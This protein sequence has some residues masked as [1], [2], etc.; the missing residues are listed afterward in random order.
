L[1]HK[2]ELVTVS[3]SHLDKTVKSRDQFAPA[4]REFLWFFGGGAIHK[5]LDLLLEVFPRHPDMILNVV[6]DVTSEVDFVEIY[7]REL[8]H[9]PNIHYHGYMIPSTSKFKNVVESTFC[10]IAPTCSESISSAVVTCLQI[11]LYPIISRDTGVDLP[12]GCGVYLEDCS[13]EEIEDAVI[14]VYNLPAAEI[15]RQIAVIQEEAL[16]NYSRGKFREKMTHFITQAIER[17]NMRPYG[18]DNNPPHGDS[19]N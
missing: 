4:K 11:G 7:Q 19:T 18:Y 5:G 17:H 9:T 10:F 15:I 16:H 12:Y 14:N 2:F 3:A 1:R 13:L 8:L 6:G